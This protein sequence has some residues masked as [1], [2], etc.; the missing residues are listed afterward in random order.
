MSNDKTAPG[1]FISYATHDRERA[2][3]I[4]A[5]LEELGHSCWIAPR[6]IRAGCDY[7]EE[8]IRGI[9]RSRCFVVL[10]S[11]AAN[12]SIYVKR[13]V[14]RAV[15]KA[16]PVF[17]VRVE[18]VLPSPAL[19]LHLAS[20]HY[21]DAWQGALREHV[22]TLA[23]NLSGAA[24]EG[25]EQPARFFNWR[26]TA[27]LVS[28]TASVLLA[29]VLFWTLGTPDAPEGGPSVVTPLGEVD[30]KLPAVR[31]PQS[32]VANYL[33]PIT[34]CSVGSGL[35]IYV[36]S[37]EGEEYVIPSGSGTNSVVSSGVH[38]EGT[39]LPW[40]GSGTTAYI[41]YSDNQYSASITLPDKPDIPIAVHVPSPE[42]H[43][44][45]LFYTAIPDGSAFFEN[46]KARGAYLF[47]APED[48]HDVEWT[49]DSKG[50]VRVERMPWN[51]RRAGPVWIEELPRADPF[52]LSIRWRKP[53]EQWTETVQ[54]FIDNQSLRQRSV[55]T[56][57]LA[58]SI[59]CS[60]DSWAAVPAHTRCRTK[61]GIPLGEI[62]AELRWGTLADDLDLVDSFDFSTWATN[63]ISSTPID[64]YEDLT[65][66]G[67]AHYSEWHNRCQT[68]VTSLI[69][70]ECGNDSQCRNRVAQSW[71]SRINAA[72]RSALSRER[73][74]LEHNSYFAPWQEVTNSTSAA[75]FLATSEQVA[76]IFFQATRHVGREPISARV[77]VS[78]STQ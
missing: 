35:N 53:G 33:G 12:G 11:A 37:P 4:C 74:I 51:D 60:R 63:L 36:R 8:I 54:Y 31:P 39:Y 73:F 49:T 59:V 61:I 9:E 26:K 71:N 19:E 77:R 44:P 5:H 1:V 45:P 42:S 29:W 14:E 43:A 28:A 3:E 75:N 38:A 27:Y 76:E 66:R 7:S 47:F 23:K 20:L 78:G 13:E 21:L 10:L 52:T 16:K 41:E 2:F 6:D 55:S 69:Q 32:C 24:I 64:G 48:T 68:Y 46:S 62:F 67:D 65:C 30:H 70:S 58:N 34:S 72:V 57:E 50:F 18:E 15:A 40:L 56:Y 22:V 25:A 17:P